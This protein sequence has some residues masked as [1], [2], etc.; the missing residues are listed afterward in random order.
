LENKD[1]TRMTEYIIPRSQL[2]RGVD[3]R[4]GKVNFITLDI[5]YQHYVPVGITSL[6]SWQD[7]HMWISIGIGGPIQDTRQDFIDSYPEGY[8]SETTDYAVPRLKA[9]V[10]FNYQGQIMNLYY[11]PEPAVRG[12]ERIDCSSPTLGSKFAACRVEAYFNDKA[13][14]SFPI[15]PEQLI[16][17]KKYHADVESMIRQ[18]MVRPNYEPQ[19]LSAEHE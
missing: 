18:I 17:F 4:N 5:L 19:C 1:A 16:D 10:D 8:I 14:Y 3:W 7:R 6:A 2:I 9:Y 13:S 11:F 15:P 12:I